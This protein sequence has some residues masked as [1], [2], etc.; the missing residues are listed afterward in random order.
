[1]RTDMKEFFLAAM[2]IVLLFFGSKRQRR[3]M[4]TKLLEVDVFRNIGLL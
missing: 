4:Q 3:N 2:V 1:L